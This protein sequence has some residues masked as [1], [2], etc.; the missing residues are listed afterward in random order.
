[1]CTQSSQSCC[2]H[3]V[4]ASEVCELSNLYLL[5]SMHIHTLNVVKNDDR[6]INNQYLLQNSILSL[7]QHIILFLYSK[8]YSI[9]YD[10]DYSSSHPIFETGQNYMTE[11]LPVPQFLFELDLAFNNVKPKDWF[12]TL[13]RFDSGILDFGLQTATAK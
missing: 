1:M 7:H 4:I 10:Y 2:E 8:C 5:L 3:F 11:K 13:I 6:Q 9:I 12:L